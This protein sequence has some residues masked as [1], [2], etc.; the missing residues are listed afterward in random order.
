MAARLVTVFGGSGFIGRHVVRAL[1]K[2]GCRVNVAVRDAEGAK[3]LKPMGDV[4]QIFPM[5]VSI[6]DPQGIARAVAGADAAINL[7]GILYERGSQTFEAIH[8]DGAKAVAEASAAAAVK[9]LVQVS[10]IGADVASRSN[11]A[12]TKALGEAAAHQAFPDVTILRPSVVF[13]PEDDFFNRFAAL[14]RFAPILPLIG[15]GETKFQPVY[16]GD[17]ASA[18]VRCIDDVATAGRVY[19]LG[20]PLIYSFRELLE[21]MLRTIK[22]RRL[23][24]PLPFAVARLQATFL[25]L[26]P[27]PPLTRDQVTLLESDN[28]VAAGALGLMDLGIHPTA[29]ESIVPTYLDRFRRK[30][31]FETSA[32]A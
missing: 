19:E 11:Y 8:R 20:G 27:V 23:L 16:V 7:V 2:S 29:A 5:P 28:V 6:R 22:R 15:G 12:R 24:V 30:G 10:A 14:A 1:A 26:L 25:Q 17:V 18:I 31:R 13:G 9:R 21:L 32:L 3:F 4:G